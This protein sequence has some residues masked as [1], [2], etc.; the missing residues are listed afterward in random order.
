[1]IA[2]DLEGL[3]MKQAKNDGSVSQ[4]KFRSVRSG[5]VVVGLLSCLFVEDLVFQAHFLC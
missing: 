2:M 5:I 4:N 3:G 1:M